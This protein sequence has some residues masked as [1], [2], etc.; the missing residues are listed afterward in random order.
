MK[1]DRGILVFLV[2]AIFIFSV[3]MVS[4]AFAQQKAKDASKDI[5]SGVAE[6]TGE[7]T[8][9]AKTDKAKMDK[10]AKKKDV[11]KDIGSGTAEAT[12]EKTTVK[13][14]PKTKA[15]MEKSAKQKDISK[16]IGSGTA[17]ATGEKTAAPA[18]K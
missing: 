18:K 2:A 15:R 11:S 7:K 17:E 14:G 8:A 12:G 5:G 13:G 1:K 4:G 16:D 9:P 6:A 10:S 3:C